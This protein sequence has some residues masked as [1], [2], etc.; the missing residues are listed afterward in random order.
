MKLVIIEGIGKKET[1]E[2]YLGKGYKVFATRGHI[3]DLPSK[4]LA[5]NVKDN[6]EPRYEII[7]TQKEIVKKLTEEAAKAEEILLATDPDREGEAISWHVAELLGLDKTDNIRIAF[8]EISKNA[9]QEALKNPRPIDENLVDAQQARRVLDRLVGY[10]LSP[11]LCKKIQSKLSAGRV[12]SV[13]LRLIVERER[14]IR[15]FKPE[16]YWPFAS[17]LNKGKKSFKATLTTKNDKKIKIGNKAEVD[18]IVAELE[19]K[20]Y[21]VTNVKKS[22]TRSKPSAPFTTSTMQQDALNKLGMSLSQTTQTAQNLYEGIEIPGEGKVAL[23][24]YIRTDSTRV[25]AGAMAEA[26]EF[27]TQNYGKEYVPNKPNIYASKKSAQDAHEAIRPITLSR[28]P[29]SLSGVLSRTNY[30]LY[31]LIYDRFLASQMSDATYDSLNVDI[32]AGDYG[33]K[34]TGKTPK[35]AGYTAVYKNFIEPKDDEGDE[36]TNLPALAEGDK[37]GFEKYKFEQKFTKP[38]ARYTEASIVKAMEEKGIGRPATYTPTVTLLFSRG[39]TEKEGKTILPTELGEKVTDMLLKYFPDIMNVKFTAGMEEQL[40]EIEDGSRI[41]R[42]VIK[43]FYAGFEDKVAMAMGDSFSLKAPDE[44]SDV[45]CES[46]GSLMVIKQGRFGKFLACPN[47]P[48]CKNTKALDSDGKPVEVEAPVEGEK[49][50][51]CGKPMVLRKGRFGDFWAC[52]GYPKCKNIKNI[53]GKEENYGT[54]PLCGKPLKAVKGRSMFFGCTGYP[55]CKFT[56]ANKVSDTKCPE[57]G[58]YMTER[59]YG[60]KDYLVCSSKECGKKYVVNNEEKSN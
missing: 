26:K 56:S 41:W 5:V 35:F 45:V 51:K 29:D 14:E 18:K 25:S 52:S 31:K 28:T 57:C 43:D 30:K 38:P 37:L 58:A 49:C 46:C 39:Y 55:D 1:V 15:A 60:G 32:K 59:K 23:V 8:N 22:V 44:K 33:F 48:K 40:D 4:T 24:T 47:Y 3:R 6:F 27:I 20:E 50:E 42:S 36:S 21:A 11:V 34:V 19:G 53:E 10:K 16:E 17:I 2:K 13:T 54:C 12:Q 9:V 7:P